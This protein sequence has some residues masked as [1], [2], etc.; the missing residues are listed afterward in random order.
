MD[1]YP[2]SFSVTMNDFLAIK[3]PFI[4]YKRLSR[5]ARSDETGS[6]TAALFPMK[7]SRGQQIEAIV[8]VDDFGSLFDQNFLQFID[9]YTQEPYINTAQTLNKV[10]HTNCRLPE[11][12]KSLASIYLMLENDLM[13][14]FCEVLF[15]QIDN[16]EIWFDKHMLNSTF[17]EACD[18]SG[19]DET[20]Y[21]QVGE[22][23]DANHAKTVASYLELISFKVEVRRQS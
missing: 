19:Y 6:L 10:L 22:S 8:Q 4:T 7:K 23:D 3:P 20:V 16:N 18:M 15:Q 9:K 14:S 11:Q 21:I 13:H 12:L 17:S 1:H 2:I 5:Q